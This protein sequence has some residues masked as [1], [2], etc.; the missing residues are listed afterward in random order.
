[1]G[2]LI[3][4][5]TLVLLLSLTGNSAALAQTTDHPW[6][7]DHIDSLP[8]EVRSAVL[9]MCAVRPN[10][11]H[12]F[13]T[14]SNKSRQINLHFE[15]YHCDEKAIFCNK[16]GCLHQTYVSSGG[17]TALITTDLRIY[18]SIARSK[19]LARHSRRVSLFVSLILPASFQCFGL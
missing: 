14:F 19:A 13:A 17:L 7:A 8:N 3:A 16:S 12:Y 4:R 11:A 6:N 1:M 10:A 15:K 5:A 18:R 2:I 9:A